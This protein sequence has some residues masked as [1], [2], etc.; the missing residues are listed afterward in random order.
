MKEIKLL[1]GDYEYAAIQE[2][3]K[4]EP[5]FK[6]TTE[7]HI[8]IIKTLEAIISPNNLMAEDVGGP[9][10][11][12]ETIMGT[13][14]PVGPTADFSTDHPL[15]DGVVPPAGAPSMPDEK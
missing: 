9:E 15:G 7:K 2:V 6:P 14:H 5:D 10:T 12:E 1:I 4:K 13:A 3:F 11:H 8:I